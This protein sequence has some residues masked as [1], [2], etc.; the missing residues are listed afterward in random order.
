MCTIYVILPILH[1]LWYKIFLD[2]NYF[3]SVCTITVALYRST[4]ISPFV[5]LSLSRTHKYTP[6]NHAEYSI[7][8][9]NKNKLESGE[10]MHRTYLSCKRAINNHKWHQNL[11]KVTLHC[12]LQWSD[13]AFCLLHMVCPN[14]N[15]FNHA[16]PSFT[17][18]A[19]HSDAMSKI[20]NQQ[21][22]GFME[23][24]QSL[25]EDT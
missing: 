20:W 25:Q 5:S 15:F 18:L 10:D 4:R 17:L 3:H 11:T 13:H 6:H 19:N 7:H 21:W 16:K 8:A 9:C 12:N 24:E 23:S 22:S 14:L 1:M 2:T